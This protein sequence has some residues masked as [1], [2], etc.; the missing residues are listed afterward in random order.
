[1]INPLLPNFLPKRCPPPSLISFQGRLARP[2]RD[3]NQLLLLLL[4]LP[5]SPP[6]GREITQNSSHGKDETFGRDAK[7]EGGGGKNHDPAKLS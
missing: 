2:T 1:M 3:L 6:W 7:E 4:L 5:P